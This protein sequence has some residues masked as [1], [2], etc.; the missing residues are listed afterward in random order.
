MI[1]VA[2]KTIKLQI[3]DTVL[4]LVLRLDNNRLSQLRVDTIDLLLELSWSTI[5]PTGNHLTMS[6][7][8]LKRQR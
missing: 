6:R 4:I 3:W 7:V 2:D 8:G 1:T 5:S